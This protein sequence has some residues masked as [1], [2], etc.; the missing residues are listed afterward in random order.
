MLEYCFGRW[1]KR[2]PGK[3]GQSRGRVGS[4]PAAACCFCSVSG[5]DVVLRLHQPCFLTCNILWVW[6]ILF[7]WEI[8]LHSEDS[9]PEYH[10]GETHAVGSLREV[11]DVPVLTQYVHLLNLQYGAFGIKIALWLST[12]VLVHLVF[13]GDGRP[14][15]M[16]ADIFF[17]GDIW[18]RRSG[19]NDVGREPGGERE[20]GNIRL[21]VVLVYLIKCCVVTFTPGDLL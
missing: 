19:G 4:T 21:P 3:S 14:V 7:F 18:L 11:G 10:E 9:Y 12:A 1:G 2:Q 20:K 6:F 13:P 5:V 15:F 16:A 17:G 8:A